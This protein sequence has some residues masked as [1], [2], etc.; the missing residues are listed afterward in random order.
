MGRSRLVVRLSV[1]VIVASCAVSVRAAGHQLKGR[2][3]VDVQR[4]RVYVHVYPTGLGHEHGVSGRLRSGYVVFG[5]TQ[6]AGE[7]IFDMKQFHADDPAARRAV[8][9]DPAASATEQRQV[10]S[11]MLGPDILDVG[12]YPMARFVIDRVELSAAPRTSWLKGASSVYQFRGHLT[13]HGVTQPLKFEAGVYPGRKGGTI[14]LRGGFRLYQSKY[15]IRPY[16]RL[17]GAVGVADHL[18]I[19]GFLVLHP[20][21][22]DR[23]K[24]TAP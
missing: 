5:A 6:R 22:P 23:H 16:K 4:S 20:A 19:Y 17:F 12:R 13:L 24:P 18:D 10:T 8:G 14:E 7:L 3:D 11:T 2:W 15:G 9:L 21:Q 1:A